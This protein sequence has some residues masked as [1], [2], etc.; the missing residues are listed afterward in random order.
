MP[1]APGSGGGN[2]PCATSVRPAMAVHGLASGSA[3]TANPSRPPG[4]STRT[5]LGDCLPGVGD[6][7][8]PEATEHRVDARVREV[9]RLGIHDAVLDVLDPALGAQAASSVD[10]GR[11]EV[12]GDH[13]PRGP[14]GPGCEQAGLAD[15]AGELEHRLAWPELEPLDQ[16]AAHGLARAPLL[17]VSPFPAWGDALPVR[18][19]LGAVVGCSRHAPDDT[20]GWERCPAGRPRTPCPESPAVGDRHPSI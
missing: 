7:H 1:G 14:D 11:R 4:L 18:A 16:V 15:A 2:A 5:N 9:D 12:G 3:Q 8:Q 17:V 10:H 13:A 19:A 6:E 20:A